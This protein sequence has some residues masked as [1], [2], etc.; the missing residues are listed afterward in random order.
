MIRQE[1]CPCCQGNG[2]VLVVNYLKSS[3]TVNCE[4][5]KGI[6]SILVEA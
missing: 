5:C 3:Q 6:G 4:A 1:V 2:K